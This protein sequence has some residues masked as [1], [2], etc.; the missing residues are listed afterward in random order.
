MAN[1][2]DEMDVSGVN[3]EGRDVHVIDKQLPV[4]LDKMD[5]FVNVGVWFLFIIGG[6]VYQFRKAHAKKYFQ[7]LQQQIQA[8]ASTID[9]Y[10]AQRVSILQNCAKLL[11]KAIQLDKDTFTEIAKYRSQ[12]GHGGEGDEARNALATRL[13]TVERSINVAFENYPDLRA[14]EQIAEA[15]Q[16]NAYL[17]QEITAA[18]RAYNDVVRLWNTAVYELWAKKYVAATNGYTTRVPFIASQEIKAKSEGVFF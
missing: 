10:Q 8:A 3:P 13:E 9:N 17:Q 15:M 5:R 7:Q 1:E 14:H 16:Q 4:K 2:L 6:V 18:R 12:A 11:D